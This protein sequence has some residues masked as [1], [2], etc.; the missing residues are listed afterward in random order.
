MQNRIESLVL[1]S[2]AIV[3]LYILYLPLVT[4]HLIDYKPFFTVT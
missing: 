2:Q 1:Q 3:H 4:S